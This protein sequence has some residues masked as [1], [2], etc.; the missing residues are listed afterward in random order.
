MDLWLLTL[1]FVYAILGSIM[2]YSASSILTVMSQNVASTYYFVRQLIILG[3]GLFFSLFIIR[4]PLSKYKLIVW[5]LIVFIVA[6]LIGLYL[7]GKNVNGAQ[8]WYDL[9]FF[10]FQPSEF[11]KTILI[12]FMA[13]YY[14]NLIKNKDMTLWKYL[15]PLGIAGLIVFL[16]F[17]QPDMG[18]AAIIF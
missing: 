4:V 17:M 18:S 3:F 2:I 14:N 15:V 12:L 9:G 8:G 13:V 6:S 7:F 16:I 10:N 1:T 5:P 11:A